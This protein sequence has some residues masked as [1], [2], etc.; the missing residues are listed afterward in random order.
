MIVACCESLTSWRVWELSNSRADAA[1]R[2]LQPP[3]RTRAIVRDGDVC[4]VLTI[5]ADARGLDDIVPAF[6]RRKLRMARHRLNRRGLWRVLGTDAMPPADWLAALGRLHA[7]RWRSRGETGVLADARM[8]TL[9]ALAL[10]ELMARGLLRCWAIEIGG[11]LAGVYLGFHHAGTAYAWLGRF[12]PEFAAFSPGAVLMGHAIEAAVLEGAETFDFL[13]GRE[14]YKYRWG[15]Q[16][17]GT[18]TLAFVRTDHAD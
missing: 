3:A 11:R 14:P 17:R 4:P 12:D 15:A 16:D 7:A 1:A 2:H 8:Q 6:Q 5:P 10:P 18:H 13:R 9:L